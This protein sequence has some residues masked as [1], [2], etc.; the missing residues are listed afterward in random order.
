MHTTIT[1]TKGRLEAPDTFLNDAGSMTLHTAEGC[2]EI[3]VPV[4]DRFGAE[5]R[6]F[7]AAILENRQPL[8]SLAYSLRNMQTLDRIMAQLQAK[9]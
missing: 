5:V 9:G 1:G 3:A 4:S 7:S 6:D 8:V 2:Q